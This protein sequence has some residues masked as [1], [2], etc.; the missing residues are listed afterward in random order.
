MTREA[1]L[2]QRGMEKLEE[3]GYA[4]AL[5]AAGLDR[6]L[7]LVG[8]MWPNAPA[9]PPPSQIF[10]GLS[11]TVDG[12]LIREGHDKNVTLCRVLAVLSP[13][14]QWDYLHLYLKDPEDARHWASLPRWKRPIRKGDKIDQHI[15]S[16]FR[17][18]FINIKSHANGHTVNL[19]AQGTQLKA[20][21]GSLYYVT[22][23]PRLASVL[24]SFGD[25]LQRGEDPG[26][27]TTKPWESKP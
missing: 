18:Y 1:Y 12:V 10:P 15:W 26:D 3:P 24:S 23:P 20:M 7:A 19:K 27:V 16:F 9:F 21:A 11:S 22:D 5:K 25:L 4:E 2:I 17:Q 6:V 8:Q 13:S 14:E